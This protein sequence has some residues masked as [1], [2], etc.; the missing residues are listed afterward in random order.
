MDQEIEDIK[1]RAGLTEET[2]DMASFEKLNEFLTDEYEFLGKLG[3]V[4]GRAMAPDRAR[5]VLGVIQDRRQKLQQFGRQAQAQARQPNAKNKQ[6][7]AEY[8][9][10]ASGGEAPTGRSYGSA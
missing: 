3:Q 4:L 10:T 1:R 7:T 2:Y 9:A 8:Q 5:E 6:G